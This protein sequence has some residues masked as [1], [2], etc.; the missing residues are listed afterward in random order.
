[1]IVGIPHYHDI[2]GLIKCIDSL[3]ASTSSID[4]ITIINSDHYLDGQKL[5]DDYGK[6]EIINTPKLG[7]LDAYNRLFELAK[8]RKEDLFLT[9][10]DVTFPKCYNRDWLD[11]MKRTA[12]IDACGIVTCYGGGG[13]SG[14]D[15]IDGYNW[16]GA[17][18]TYIPYRTIEKIGGYDMNIPLGWGV[19]ID[20]TYAVEMAGL[21]V[22]VIN[23]W[24]DHHP[25]YKEGHKHEKRDDL[26]KLQKEA[27][28]YMRKKW[29]L[30]R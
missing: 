5:I 1:M 18:C 14:P 22:Y 29:K 12:K 11:D 21:K 15:F 2:Y 4:V 25:N 10:T 8:E 3:L 24:V 13:Q 9:Q 28:T 16:V 6:I 7:P 23:Y 20:Y 27:F 30:E 19:D 26:E 17:W